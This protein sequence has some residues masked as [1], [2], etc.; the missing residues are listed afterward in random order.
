VGFQYF[1]DVDLTVFAE[2]DFDGLRR[3]SG[4]RRIIAL[5]VLAGITN[6]TA[7]GAP[8]N[9]YTVTSDRGANFA[10]SFVRVAFPNPDDVL[11]AGALGA[12]LALRCGRNSPQIVGSLHIGR[13]LEP[14]RVVGGRIAKVPAIRQVLGTVPPPKLESRRAFRRSPD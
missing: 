10:N 5:H 1:I 7:N 6:V 4:R 12:M 8:I 11:L 9:T 3:T 13:G 14:T 2:G